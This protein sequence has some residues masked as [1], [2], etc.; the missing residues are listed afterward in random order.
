MTAAPKNAL[1]SMMT[2]FWVSQSIYVAAKLGLAD[3]LH[4]GPQTADQLAKTTQT[5]S[6]ALYRLLRAAG[7]R[8]NFSGRR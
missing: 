4:A 3:L 5:R 8:G 6:E 2:G 7:E 1:A